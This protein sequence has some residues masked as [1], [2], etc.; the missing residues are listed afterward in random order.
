MASSSMPPNIWYRVPFSFW[1]RW[2]WN[3]PSEYSATVSITFWY[4]RSRRRSHRAEPAVTASANR[5]APPRAAPPKRSVLWA[6]SASS[7]SGVCSVRPA[8]ASR[9]SPLAE[10][11]VFCSA[12]ARTGP[13]TPWSSRAAVTVRSRSSRTCCTSAACRKHSPSAASISS[14]PVP[15]GNRKYRQDCFS[16]RKFMARPSSTGSRSPGP[17]PGTPGGRGRARSSPA[18]GGCR[19]TGYCRPQSRRCRP[20]AR[21]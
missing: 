9:A 19:P 4:S 2:R 6:G 7:G 17:S 1:G 8:R 3:F 21:P 11:A 10:G 15:S 16:R 20:T 12:A 5:A 13:G 18:G 14:S